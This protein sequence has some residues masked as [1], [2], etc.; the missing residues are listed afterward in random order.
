MKYQKG[1]ASLHTATEDD[2]CFCN[3]S[4][5]DKAA[6]L[7]GN[8]KS[9]HI[10][11]YRHVLEHINAKGF[12]VAKQLV[13]SDNP[14]RSFIQDM[15]RAGIN[16]RSTEFPNVWNIGEKINFIGKSEVAN[17]IFEGR[18]TIYPNCTIG[19]PAL[20]YERSED[21]KQMLDF[22]HIGNV[23]LGDNVRVGPGTNISRGTLE[24]TIIGRET[25]IDAH[26]HV[27]HNVEIGECCAL[28]AD[29][30]IG[31]SAKIGTHTW[32]GLNCTI[33]DHVIIGNHVIVGCQ[34]N[35]I[36]DVPDKTVV[37]GNPAKPRSAEN[38]NPIMRKRLAGF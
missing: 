17:V 25:M 5:P 10:Y 8:C 3:E 37:I 24:D 16:N 20:S 9:I 32:L 19:W 7:L 22:P 12:R 30:C 36:D 4:D 15:Y 34:A 23:R 38:M 33:K 14:R 6:I 31:G 11:V 13:Y 18:A 35:V 1:F 28:A 29:T 21:M 2:V 26:C 27:A